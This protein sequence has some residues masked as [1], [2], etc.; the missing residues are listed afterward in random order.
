M[1]SYHLSSTVLLISGII[2]GF[3][4]CKCVLASRLIVLRFEVSTPYR[5]LVDNS[6]FW[7]GLL[8]A[9]LN[10]RSEVQM[11]TEDEFLNRIKISQFT[12]FEA[13]AVLLDCNHVKCYQNPKS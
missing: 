12:K 2:I 8:F 4:R 3:P 11:E 5:L 1:C 10:T 13:L 7:E 6:V 9:E